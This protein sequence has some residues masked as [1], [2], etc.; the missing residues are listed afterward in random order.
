MTELHID[1]V[2]KRFGETLVLDEIEFSVPSGSFV[3]IVGPSGCGKTTLLRSL[4]GL[5]GIDSG[6]IRIAGRDVT[7][8]EPSARDVA[9]VFQNY[10]L[11]PTKTVY[12]NMAYGLRL[13]GTP[14]AEIERRVRSAA[15]RLQIEHLLPRRPSQLS[16][17]QRQ[18]VAMGRA[19]V[20]EPSLFLFD[21]PLSNLDAA[22]RNELRVEIKR[23]QRSLNVT[24][25][26]V[27][28]D[29]HEAMTLADLLVVMRG[30]RIEQMGS[31]KAIY[32]RPLTRFA[33]G[34]LGTPP[35]S[36]VPARLSNGKLSFEGG[37]ELSAAAG[38]NASLEARDVDVGFR[39][40]DVALSAQASRDTV[41]G[42]VELVEELGATRI[43]HLATPLGGFIVSL[44]ADGAPPT[45]EVNLRLSGNRLSIF[46]R[47]S[48]R[49][50]EPDGRAA[51]ARALPDSSSAGAGQGMHA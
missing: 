42:R 29:Q 20:R 4:A 13:R 28:H 43:V 9:M 26:Y 34:F 14:R 38:T 46:D 49:R 24:T 15:R 51:E 33:A 31:P 2:S 21:E 18:R 48:G 6:A 39:P 25:V 41:Q 32:D 45:A 30:G 12:E 11:Y 37:L 40:E 22:L 10:A 35:M 23:L 5:E 44:S 8:L 36:F 1:R 16:G 47:E 27:T 50:L 17:G 7:D 19:I 3:V